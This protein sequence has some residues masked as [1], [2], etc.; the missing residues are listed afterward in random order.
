MRKLIF[1]VVIIGLL[2]GS[3]LGG[4][5]IAQPT[6]GPT[7]TA[8][9]TPTPEH[10]PGKGKS[11]NLTN[12]VDVVDENILAIM[13]EVDNIEAKLDNPAYGLEE[14][15]REV[16]S[17][18]GNVTEIK[19]EVTAIDNKVSA[20]EV[21][22][23]NVTRTRN[24]Q[25]AVWVEADTWVWTYDVIPVPGSAHF[26][27]TVFVDF[28][29]PG[30]SIR[31][32]QCFKYTQ[33]PWTRCVYEEITANGAYTFEFAGVHCYIETKNIFTSGSENGISVNYHAIVTSGGYL[34]AS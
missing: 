23:D 13:Y 5:A 10:T 31:V 11:E 15:K 20:I 24:F 32:Y 27:L 26:Y 30:E 25:D 33:T 21:E 8:T 12:V 29:D 17:I 34:P 7:P 9:P 3:T 1:A 22:L 4:L 28:L 14:I 6:P 19:A 16:A 18:E 2:V